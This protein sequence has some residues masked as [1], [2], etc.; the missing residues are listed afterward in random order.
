[1][2]KYKSIDK[3]LLNGNRLCLDFVNTIHDR[4]HEPDN[5]YLT[6]YSQLLQW[7]VKTGIMNSRAFHVS[8]EATSAATTHANELLKE[9]KLIRELLYRMFKAVSQREK[10][11]GKDLQAFN[12]NLPECF[13]KLQI[14]PAKKG[15]TTYWKTTS[16]Q[17][18][19]VMAPIIHSAYELLLLE[20]LERVKEC[21][22]CGWL[23]LDTTKNGRRRWCSMKTCGSSV[24][25]LEWYRRQKEK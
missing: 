6:S 14:E 3:V 9:A 23:F 10:I 18:W 4:V 25:A 17:L 7:S 20:N 12:A 2:V 16:D 21:P 11:S 24:K 15:Y 5:D 19:V 1:M 8:L 22:N 13:S